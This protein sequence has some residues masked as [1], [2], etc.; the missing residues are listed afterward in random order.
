[1]TDVVRTHSEDETASVAR[2][3]AAT[4]RPGAIVL[5]TGDLGAGKTC[6][7]R[8][9]AAGLGIDPDEVSSPTF[10]LIHEYREPQGPDRPSRLEGRG[11]RI[12]VHVDLYRLE[13]A[14]V[15]DLG[16]EELSEGGA[17]VAIEWAEKLGAP[18]AGAIRVEIRDCGGDVREIVIATA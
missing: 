1:M 5:L 14:E 8:G 4:L 18:P 9:M 11:E 10:A 6:F 12:L 15:D 17:V 7:V 2:S 16:L 3:I 13:G